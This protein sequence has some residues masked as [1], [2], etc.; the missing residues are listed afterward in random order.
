MKGG[1]KVSQI[2]LILIGFVCATILLLAYVKSLFLSSSLLPQNH[3]LQLSPGLY[4]PSDVPLL[5]FHFFR[6]YVL[7]NIFIKFKDYGCTL[8]WSSLLFVLEHFHTKRRSPL[9]TIQTFYISFE[10]NR[11]FLVE[12]RLWV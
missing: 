4:K 7:V 10:C 2:S 9:L 12:M 8:H 1:L 11:S 6:Y 5:P 3:V